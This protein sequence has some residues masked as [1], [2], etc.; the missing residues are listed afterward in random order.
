[1]K[2][3]REGNGKKYVTSS[4]KKKKNERRSKTL[5]VV[6]GWGKKTRWEGW[7]IKCGCWC[8]RRTDMRR[9]WG[10]WLDGGTRKQGFEDA[11]RA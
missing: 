2:K 5:E 10:D 8:K 7:I 4:K 6:D 11:G 1:M 9:Q 3:E